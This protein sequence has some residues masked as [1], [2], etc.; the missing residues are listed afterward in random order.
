MGRVWEEQ[1]PPET[2]PLE[3]ILLCDGVRTTAA[4]ARE[5]ASQY[6]ARGLIEDF[7]KALKSGL[8]AER[9][10]LKKAAELCAAIAIMSVV[11]V[12]LVEVR[13]GGAAPPRGAMCFERAE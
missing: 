2:E 4:Q 6:A 12:R 10:Q 8:G 11:A 9:L 7:H 3:W 1:P 5:C 13:Y